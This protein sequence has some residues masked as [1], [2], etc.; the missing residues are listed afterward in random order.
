MDI[1]EKADWLT[2]FPPSEYLFISTCQSLSN[3]K[4]TASIIQSLQNFLKGIL[5]YLLG[6]EPTMHLSF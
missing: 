1:L 2:I 3:F 4:I 6:I 5:K